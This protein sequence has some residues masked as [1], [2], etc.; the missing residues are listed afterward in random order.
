[1]NK[2]LG[3][4]LTV[5]VAVLLAASS[6]WAVNGSGLPGDH[7]RPDNGVQPVK[8]PELRHPRWKVAA[9][10]IELAIDA[11]QAIAGGCKQYRLGIAVVN[12]EGQPI[13]GYIPDGSN[14]MHFYF[15]LRKA[16][17]AVVFKV[18]TSQLIPK[19]RQD[20][21]LAARIKADSNLAV[22]VGGL[23]LK[24]NGKVIGAIGVSGAEPGSHD[25][26]C[27]M[28]GYRKIEAALTKEGSQS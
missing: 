8:I 3:G 4:K 10:P 5:A 22:F 1:M 12:S 24:V 18:P 19:A 14:P 6:A 21:A 9:P 11:A 13:L 20:A 26:Q 27:G 25:E 2:R 28:I 23:P 15:A 16:Y 17:T 7:G